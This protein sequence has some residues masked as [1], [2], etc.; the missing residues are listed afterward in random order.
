MG[1]QLSLVLSLIHLLFVD[2][3]LIFHSGSVRD[4]HTLKDIRALFTLA[5]GMEINEGKSSVTAHLLTVEETRELGRTFPFSSMGLDVGLKYLRF[6]LKPNDYLKQD[7]Y[8]LIEKLEK[9][10]KLWSHKWLS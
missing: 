10:L 6:C 9:R 4:T 7:W 1:I 3:I 8:W 2:A 5:T